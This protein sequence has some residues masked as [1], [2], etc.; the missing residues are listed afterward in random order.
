MVLEEELRS[1]TEV[2]VRGIP[3]GIVG[4]V[5]IVIIILAILYFVL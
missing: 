3:G 4:L 1:V 5:V 2:S